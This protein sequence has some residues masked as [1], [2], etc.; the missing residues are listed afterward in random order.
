[1]TFRREPDA[2]P[3]RPVTRVE[4]SDSSPRTA[5]VPAGR[6]TSGAQDTARSARNALLWAAVVGLAL[7]WV[8]RDLVLLVGYSVLLAYALLPVVAALERPF[9][10]R[11]PRLPRSAAAAVV[12][13]G[14]V[15]VVGWLLALAVPRVATQAAHFASG[16]PDALA[17][18]VQGTQA[19]G[20][21]HGL[22]VWLDPVIEGVRANVSGLFEDLGGNLAG[23][24]GRGLGGL[25]QVLGLALLP[26][27]AFYLLA[28]SRAVQVSALRFVPEG[29]HGEIVRLG[30]AVDRALR[31][32]VRGQAIVCLVMGIAVGAT[33]ALL[34]SPVALLLGLLVGVAE[35]VPYLG[36][37]VA[38]V[39][40]ALAGLSVSPLQALAG[41]AAYAVI[42]WAI[43]TFVTPQVMGRY[44]KMHPFIV[45]VSV[46]A[47]TQIFGPAGALLALPGAAVLQAVVGELAVPAASR[48]EEEPLVPVDVRP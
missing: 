2:S 12:M 47:G 19:Y 13:L 23:W 20:A 28:E 1:M 5:P 30:G 44:L 24:A 34:G 9:G 17:R 45:T 31:S 6:V 33:L 16:A 27:L 36:F 22:S 10:R 25:G 29:A 41:V 21:A 26:L 43:G 4:S 15:A 7:V 11:G 40:V 3:E 37:L 39:A 38:A 42:N 18:L 32:Y 46:L 8:L 48:T 14:L 35:L